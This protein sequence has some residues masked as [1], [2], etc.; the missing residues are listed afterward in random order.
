MPA[1]SVSTWKFKRAQRL[2]DREARALGEQPAQQQHDQRRA[3][4]RQ[5][6]PDLVQQCAQRIHDHVQLLHHVL[7]RSPGLAYVAARA[8]SPASGTPIQS[9][10]LSIS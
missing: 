2:D 4:P 7:P 5:E 10:R 6:H 1:R 9:G 8:A 3:Q